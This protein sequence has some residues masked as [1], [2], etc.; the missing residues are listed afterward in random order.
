MM[1]CVFYYR[2]LTVEEKERLQKEEKLNKADKN[3]AMA[4]EE[5][6]NYRLVAFIHYII[7]IISLLHTLCC[8]ISEN[9]QMRWRKSWRKQNSPTRPRYPHMRRRLITTG[10]V[11]LPPQTSSKRA[12]QSEISWL[13]QPS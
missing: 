7:I 12:K 2:M 6:N 11:G 8:C 4:L 5:L 13:V 10:L 9:E 1:R 3:I